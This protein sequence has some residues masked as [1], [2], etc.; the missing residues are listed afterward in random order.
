[1]AEE[2]EN[3]ET[4]GQ[5]LNL[6]LPLGKEAASTG[7]KPKKKVARK[8]AKKVVRKV[9]KKK[10]APKKKKAAPA[11]VEI[12]VEAPVPAPA[13]KPIA[14]KKRVT[15]ARKVPVSPPVE[16]KME[17]IPSPT[18]SPEVAVNV[19]SEIPNSGLS[20]PD[21]SKGDVIKKP[22]RGRGRKPNIEP[23]IE[24]GTKVDAATAPEPAPEP[25]PKP[26]PAPDPG[27]PAPELINLN[28][29]Q[30]K[31]VSELYELGASLGLRV[32]GIC[33]KHQLIYEILTHWG[34][35]GTKV[36]AEGVLETG[37][38][39]QFGFLRWPVYSFMPFQEDIYV[40]R[41][42]IRQYGLK[43]GHLVKGISHPPRDREKFITMD[44]VISIEGIPAEKWQEP[45]P[46][47][48]L[49]A[50][51]PRERLIL[52]G[53][54]AISARVVDIVAPLGKGQRGIIV[55]P[56]RGGKTIMLKDIAKAITANH[57]EVEVIILLLDERPEEVTDFEESVEATV[58]SSTFDEAPERHIQVA[59]L[60]AE[61]AK[62]LV[63]LKRDVVILMDS[64]TRLAR[65]YNGLT[66]GGGRTGSG[67][68]DTKALPKSRKIFNIARN[69]EEGGSLT[70]LATALVDTGARMD[71]VIFEEFKGS[72]NMEIELDR[73]LLEMRIFPAINIPK[74][75]TRKDDL[76]YH[77]D[78]LRRINLIR[79]QLAARPGG[80][81]IEVLVRNIRNTKS[82]AE[83]LM[84]G[85]LD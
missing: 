33:S 44:E 32:G 64:L 73:E 65:G 61:R 22:R 1:M 14:V 6:E 52:E 28:E 18:E 41:A 27:P 55:A 2:N 54:D 16:E 77:P 50:I 70:M 76:L 68:M 75:G 20:A 56:P 51:S 46:F 78:E 40:G 29:F 5:D 66:K 39:D 13:P 35:R 53:R 62:R 8:V 7:A 42:L 79:R 4:S 67:G 72:G 71:Q 84:R 47:D 63:E 21:E 34:R 3:T 58:Y 36:E 48:D 12:E 80:E 69:V 49:T 26:E 83:L 37:Q 15:R 82:N 57:P 11:K 9:A 85:R 17:L 19:E 81:A 38:T 31:P 10:V 25:A 30:K 45:V 74:S 60:V 43:K 23:Q 24:T 59:E